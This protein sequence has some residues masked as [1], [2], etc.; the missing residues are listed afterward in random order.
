MSSPMVTRSPSL[1]SAGAMSTWPCDRVTG[2]LFGTAAE[3]SA[4]GSSAGAD[5]AADCAL[6]SWAVPLSAYGAL[7][8]ESTFT[9]VAP[10]FTQD[11]GTT[12]KRHSR[13]LPAQSASYSP[14]RSAGVETKSTSQLGAWEPGRYNPP[15]TCSDRE[16]SFGLTVRES[17]S[18]N[19]DPCLLE[20]CTSLDVGR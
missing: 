20:M 1:V 16:S 18:S 7:A 3:S 9:V 4:L 12:V 17:N 2:V 13:S 14:V 15:T 8:L 5:G 11:C 10:G 6:P 19:A